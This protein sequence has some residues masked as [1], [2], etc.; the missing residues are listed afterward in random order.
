[1]VDLIL[2][3]SVALSG[4]M[5]LFRNR[6][7]CLLVFYLSNLLYHYGVIFNHISTGAFTDIPSLEAKAIITV[8]FSSIFLVQIVD[9]FMGK[10]NAYS[11]TVMA[12]ASSKQ[13]QRVFVSFL[14]IS[15][16]ST[17]IFICSA[18]VDIFD[19]KASSKASAIPFS[20]WGSYYFAF[21]CSGYFFLTRRH[22]AFTLTTII[23]LFYLFVGTR[24]FAVLF[25]INLVILIMAQKKLFSGTTI[26]NFFVLIL[27]FLSL[28]LY[29]HM[30]IGLKSLEISQTAEF[31]AELNLQKLV[32]MLFS[33]EWSQIAMNTHRVTLIENKELYNFWD[34]LVMALPGF[35][36]WSHLPERFSEIIYFHANPGYSYGLGGAFWSEI[37]YAHGLLGVFI[38]SQIVLWYVVYCNRLLRRGSPIYLYHAPLLIFI[39]FYLPRN[40]FS[41]LLASIKNLI[42]SLILGLALSYVIPW[43][44]TRGTLKNDA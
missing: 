44:V 19:G 11:V 28:A 18:G 12:F 39:S 20:F 8:V 40:D 25:A 14:Y 23:I 7:D 30:Y 13:M 36:D 3:I 2:F 43:K 27:V 35:N 16:F 21:A 34:M 42:I 37:W 6:I 9:A 17:A 24:A 26:K 1:M 15:L 38:F 33:A 29:K 4:L 32:W 31:F 41:L 10:K 5:C 22:Y